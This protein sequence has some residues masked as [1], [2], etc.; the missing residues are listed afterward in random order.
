MTPTREG[1][2]T[3]R[4]RDLLACYHDLSCALDRALQERHGIG[5]SEFEA[6]DLLVDAG[7]CKFRMQ[8]LAAGM[9]LSQSALSR[10][11]ARL[12]RRGLATRTMCEN[13]RRAMFVAV[14]DTGRD[15]HA[16]ARPT[17]RSVLAEHL[18]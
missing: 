16:L 5:M 7:D 11:V 6:L 8:D 18:G 14:T 13:D 12:E 1:E 4:W 15:L 3:A 10:T 2:L 9:H 17:H